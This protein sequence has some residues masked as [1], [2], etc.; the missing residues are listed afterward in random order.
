MVSEFIE[1]D[2]IIESKLGFGRAP[3]F[4]CRINLCHLAF[5]EMY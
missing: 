2:C 4:L 5:F 1:F 3:R